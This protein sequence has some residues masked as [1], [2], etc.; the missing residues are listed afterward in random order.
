MDLPAED[1]ALSPVTGWT[2]GHWAAVGHEW[3]A[4]VRRFSSPLG[5]AT[6]LPGRAT[7]DGERRESMEAV[8]RSFLL[9]AP[10]VA[11]ADDAASDE[12]L[13]WYAR[14]LLA[15]T[16]PDGPEA[17]PLGVTCRFP[18][19]GVTNNIVEAANIAFGLHVSRD[20]LWAGLT[21]PERA[22]IAS[23]LRHHARLEV[24]H[25]NWQLFPAMA[26]GFLRSVDED[27]T[28][29]IGERNVARV[30]SW[31]LEQGWYTDG[32]EHALDHYNA[33]AIHP[34]LWAWYEMTGRTGTPEGIRH[35]ERLH[36]FTASFSDLVAPDGSLLHMGRSL[37]YR[38]AALAAVWC[39]ELS[40]ANA[41]TPGRTRA[42]A[43]G[44]L[45]RFVDAGVGAGEPLG[46]GW[47]RP[48]EPI[49]QAYSGFGS[50]YLAGIGFL[51]LALPASAPVW[52]EDEEPRVP[53]PRTIP[54]AGWI[55]TP[56]SDGIVRLA[57]HG[58]DHCEIPVE[59]TRPDP[60]DPHYA[61]LGYSTH[62]A[63]GTGPAFEEGIDGHLALIGDDGRA[64]RR[65][66]I[67]A[68]RAEGPVAAS[69]HIPQR[70]GI[71]FPGVTVASATIVEGD[72]EIRAHLV[73]SDRPWPVREGGW[74]IAGDDA[75]AAASS[76]LAASATNANGLTGAIVGLTGWSSAEIARVDGSDAFGPR[77]A[78]PVL[79][80]SVPAGETLLVSL[81]ALSA[82]PRDLA[83]AAEAAVSGTSLTVR[84]ATGRTHE[85]DLAAFLWPVLS[86]R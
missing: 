80:G 55:L 8:G 5:A 76:G 78:V 6:R 44:V 32:P 7:G 72:L 1:R 74:Q 18:V 51:G 50:P 38:T 69:A 3:L 43:S 19:T 84:W 24:W 27:V 23:W 63:P 79:R 21:R 85:I 15:G 81:H 17:W 73:R 4:Q 36:D 35:R 64:S 12:V 48:H 82:A 41:L 57:N 2:R 9:A 62:T 40:G 61:K 22:R 86:S 53:G 60:D 75:P 47:L 42:L 59:P 26:E 52:A 71:P 11:G 20:R 33:W 65:G 45:R 58:S 37:T 31:Y 56:Q 25:N 29:C 30:E 34:Y 13:A 66:P 83:G 49:A 39:A 10:L 70:D 46:L 54:R 68:M 16:D 14:A 67:R 77:A 28:G